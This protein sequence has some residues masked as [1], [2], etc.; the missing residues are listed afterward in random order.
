MPPGWFKKKDEVGSAHPSWLDEDER[1]AT[2]GREAQD[3]MAVGGDETSPLVADN[4]GNDDINGAGYGGTTLD[5][6]PGDDDDD[7]L[8]GMRSRDEESNVSSWHEEDGSPTSPSSQEASSS[9][10]SSSSRP[11][12]LSEKS[13]TRTRMNEYKAKLEDRR[14]KMLSGLP[15][16]NCCHGLFIFL[17]IVAVAACLSYDP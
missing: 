12:S 15:R 17:N 10:R 6:L 5:A 9:R 7:G 2:A 13:S 4:D 11:A 16:R 3:D 14:R 1:T 8:P